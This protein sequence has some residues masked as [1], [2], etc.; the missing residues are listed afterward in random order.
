MTEEEDAAAAAPDDDKYGG[1]DECLCSVVFDLE[2][3]IL[4][5]SNTLTCCL[6]ILQQKQSP[7]PPRER[8]RPDLCPAFIAMTDHSQPNSR[9]TARSE[10]ERTV[11]VEL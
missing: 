2:T 4:K 11:R 8:C 7:Y 5:S 1:E 6:H 3:S 10:Q 9:A